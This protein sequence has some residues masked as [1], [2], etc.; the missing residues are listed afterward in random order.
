VQVKRL[1]GKIGYMLENKEEKKLS[2]AVT[3][4]VGRFAVRIFS[5]K[6]LENN[7]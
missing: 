6:V 1:A 2:W 5:D 4:G 7:P 3:E